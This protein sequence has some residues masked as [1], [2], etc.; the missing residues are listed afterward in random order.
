MT[1]HVS[2]EGEEEVE[3]VE[4][5][6]A[7]E[8]EEGL[9]VY[10]YIL[11]V[12]D[13][14]VQAAT[15]MQRAYRLLKAKCKSG[16]MPS[17]EDPFHFKHFTRIRSLVG[18]SKDELFDEY[19]D[20]RERTDGGRPRRKKKREGPCRLMDE[21]RDSQL[22]K[23]SDEAHEVLLKQLEAARGR[24]SESFASNDALNKLL[25]ARSNV[26][27]VSGYLRERWNKMKEEETNAALLKNPLQ[28][29]FK[30][31]SQQWEKLMHW[32][33]SNGHGSPIKM[34]EPALLDLQASLSVDS[35]S[36][37]SRIMSLLAQFN[38]I[39]R[40]KQGQMPGAAGS[41]TNQGLPAG[42]NADE[43]QQG[44][45]VNS[46][47]VGLFDWAI[48]DTG[49]EYK[50]ELEESRR[51]A[52]TPPEPP[53]GLDSD[54][55]RFH[56][57]VCSA[58]KSSSYRTCRLRKSGREFLQAFE[59][60]T[61][62]RRRL[63]RTRSSGSLGLL[64]PPSVDP[65]S[66]TIIHP[67]AGKPEGS[68]AK[69]WVHT[70]LQEIVRN[71]VKRQNRG[72]G[73][74]PLRCI[75]TEWMG[76]VDW[77]MI[78]SRA[79]GCP[80]PK[81]LR[82][83]PKPTDQ[84]LGDLFEVFAKNKAAMKQAATEAKGTERDCESVTSVRSWDNSSEALPDDPD[85]PFDSSSLYV[86][87]V[88]DILEESGLT[89]LGCK[90][91][92]ANL[93]GSARAPLL[94]LPLDSARAAAAA[95]SWLQ[96]APGSQESHYYGSQHARL[97]HC[98]HAFMGSAAHDQALLE[99]A[100]D[101]GVAV[102][103]HSLSDL[104]PH[105]LGRAIERALER[106]LSEGAS[107]K[108][109]PEITWPMMLHCWRAA[110]L[111]GW[112]GQ[113]GRALWKAMDAFSPSHSLE[114]SSLDPPSKSM[115]IRTPIAPPSPSS[116]P[117]FSPATPS[118]TAPCPPTEGNAS[119][120]APLS[121][122]RGLSKSD[123]LTPVATKGAG[124][125]TSASTPSLAKPKHKYSP[126][127]GE[128]CT[129]FEPYS[130]SMSNSFSGSLAS[131]FAASSPSQP[132][133]LCTNGGASSPS[134]MMQ[135][136]AVARERRRQQALEAQAA[137]RAK[138]ESWAYDISPKASLSL[139]TP[140]PRA[141]TSSLKQSLVSKPS[142]SNSA[143]S[144][145]RTGLRSEASYRPGAPAP[146]RASSVTGGAT[147][148]SDDDEDEEKGQEEL[149]ESSVVGPI[150]SDMLLLRRNEFWSNVLA[151]AHVI[152]LFAEHHMPWRPYFHGATDK[153]KQLRVKV[154]AET[155]Q[156]LALYVEHHFNLQKFSK[157]VRVHPAK[158][159]QAGAEA[160]KR[161]Q[162]DWCKL[163]KSEVYKWLNRYLVLGKLPSN[164]TQV[165]EESSFFADPEHPD[166]GHKL[167]Q[168]QE[169]CLQVHSFTGLRERGH[170]SKPEPEPSLFERRL[171]A[172]EE[173]PTES[174]STPL[175]SVDACLATLSG[176][177]AAGGGGSASAH[178][179]LDPEPASLDEFAAPHPSGARPRPHLQPRPS[180]TA[181]TFVSLQPHPPPSSST[182]SNST[183][184]PHSTKAKSSSTSSS[185]RIPHPPKTSSSTST[186]TTHVPHPP[187]TSSSTSTTTTSLHGDQPTRSTAPVHV[188]FMRPLTSAHAAAS[189]LSM[190][191]LS[192][193][194][195]SS[196]GHTIS[197]QCQPPPTSAPVSPKS[198]SSTGP[199][200]NP[201]CQPPTS[202][203]VSL[204]SSSS[205]GPTLSPLA[206]PQPPAYAPHSPPKVQAIGR[207]PSAPAVARNPLSKVLQPPACQP[208]LPA[209]GPSGEA[210]FS[211]GPVSPESRSQG[212]HVETSLPSII[213][214]PS[215]EDKDCT[216]N[217]SFDNLE[218]FSP[219]P[220]DRGNRSKR[221][222]WN[223]SLPR[224][225]A[226]A[227]PLILSCGQRSL[228][229]HDI[230]FEHPER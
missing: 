56:A 8:Q 171:H 179:I 2:S 149:E 132:S 88:H 142:S 1:M 5:E 125:A 99:V 190:R 158:V 200:V 83:P 21:I 148:G 48:K 205:M 122:S 98:E 218:R 30:H 75:N 93:M 198:R 97:L 203:P 140:K 181:Q 214:Q 124:L 110:G 151:D 139:Q 137:N 95:E 86:R 29:E 45:K 106:S 28:G 213:S 7:S 113:D 109:S 211:S 150:N 37:R 61:Q 111:P 172:I 207:V 187:K 18:W 138:R 219:T 209:P 4:G 130:P 156:K 10:H 68:A 79:T 221:A 194:S 100:K 63:I 163:V 166:H 47:A 101:Q 162:L 168:E 164:F 169:P 14:S 108:N 183:C 76:G 50:E 174:T 197:P 94:L 85:I 60:S 12:F 145:P 70:Q 228:P 215:W 119:L 188:P 117:S 180:S 154:H 107:N 74:R 223:D 146:S 196:L 167:E 52:A 87:E 191:S 32:M 131:S 133:L 84:E 182:S 222:S 43:G 192:L 73:G 34:H 161:M 41:D 170:M 212:L 6:G 38:T 105:Q 82:I 58:L 91:V 39:L 22:G 229:K 178:V 155:V 201:Q 40:I 36:H 152:V 127:G 208:H 92:L 66:V 193:R 19:G 121:A 55:Y 24:W 80:P 46:L 202:A 220:T 186:T 11:E 120:F 225:Q 175:T 23:L 53:E 216:S 90:T 176:G 206:Y 217:Q 78:E 224:R 89:G 67:M 134:A 72:R 195:S 96:A 17:D 71:Q 16:V 62:K 3:D 13:R 153:Q 157:A 49:L 126:G 143:T 173:A 102:Q 141:P 20:R 165:Q 77:R 115:H 33:L 185:T 210:S 103:A 112:Q 230:V 226:V 31:G 9:P 118:P 104:L 27:M 144:R 26:S 65:S 135:A 114:S 189:P 160:R 227:Y 116:A 51:Y 81:G 42:P 57:Q 177:V 184:V 199:S 59:D 136:R 128:A 204:K 35:E 15:V 159:T 64:G 69:Q 54:L 123:S 129:P 44:V 147:S 25:N